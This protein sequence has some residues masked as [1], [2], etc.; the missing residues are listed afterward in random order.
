MKARLPI[1]QILLILR[2]A[3]NRGN[4]RLTCRDHGI[5]ERTFYRWQNKFGKLLAADWRR[6]H[7]LEF[8][9]EQLRRLIVELTFEN[10]NLKEE[11][12]RKTPMQSG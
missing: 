8:E 6:T 11:N 12:T 5:S 7:I 2:E 1:E 10:S 3:E 4:V 9:N